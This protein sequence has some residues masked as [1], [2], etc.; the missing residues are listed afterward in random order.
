MKVTPKDS[1]EEAEIIK[2]LLILE[3]HNGK[4]ELGDFIKEYDPTLT[5]KQ[6]ENLK[7]RISKW[8]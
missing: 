7:K 2:M 1:Y 4:M 8:T 6:I 3:K 5:P